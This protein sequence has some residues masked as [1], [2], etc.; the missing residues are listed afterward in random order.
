MKR[1]L[2]LLITAVMILSVT[3]CARMP[4]AKTAEKKIYKFFHKYGKKYPDTIYG[5][6]PVKSVEVTDMEEIHK[7]FI[8]ADAFL[9]LGETEVAKINATL[10]RKALRWRVV[11]WENVL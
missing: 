3:S 7:H 1:Y 5:T 4:K 9:M 8:S 10:E 6:M 11:S 2:A